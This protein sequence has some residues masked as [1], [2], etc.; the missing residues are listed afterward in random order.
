MLTTQGPGRPFVYRR[1]PP[2][3]ANAQTPLAETVIAR[4]LRPFRTALIERGVAP[5]SHGRFERAPPFAAQSR[6]STSPPSVHNTD[7][8]LAAIVGLPCWRFRSIYANAVGSIALAAYSA[9]ACPVISAVKSRCV[10]AGS[11]DCRRIIKKRPH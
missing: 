2:R 1:L 3:Q 4:A 10:D 11:G 5:G 6:V 7:R 8:I 9:C